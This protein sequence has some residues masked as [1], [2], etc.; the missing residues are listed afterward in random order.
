MLQEEYDNILEDLIDKEIMKEDSVSLIELSK[1]FGD[2]GF[3]RK[4]FL[5]VLMKNINILN[6]AEEDFI[7]SY[8]FAFCKFDYLK[9]PSN[10]KLLDSFAFF[11]CTINNMSIEEGLQEIKSNVFSNLKSLQKI[12]F[13]S[14]LKKIG[15]L[16]FSFNELET[17]EL[18]SDIEEIEDFAFTQSR[19]LEKVHIGEISNLGHR[20]FSNSNLNLV[21][22]CSYKE[23]PF[24]WKSDWDYANNYN[25]DKYSID[26]GVK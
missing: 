4:Q 5:E 18:N 10:I 23:R 9:I 24:A 19:K 2:D 3:K 1:Y 11:N 20:I 17:L 8:L 25:D 6:F 21:I 22:S 26:W 13:P 14:T 16:A 12:Q 7:P 15:K